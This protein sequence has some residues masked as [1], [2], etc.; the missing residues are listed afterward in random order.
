M[1]V[2]LGRERTQGSQVVKQATWCA[3]G[4]PSGRVRRA[5]AGGELP[6]LRAA[7]RPRSSLSRSM[8]AVVAAR[9]G[10]VT[11]AER[12]FHETAATDL[13][14][15]RGGSAGGVRIAALGGLWQTAMFGFVGLSLRPDGVALDPQLP[16]S[17]RVVTFRLQWRGRRLRFRLDGGSRMAGVTLERGEPMV[18]HVA[19]R[20]HGLELGRTID[21]GWS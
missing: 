18:V 12:Y 8:H 21:A 1:D 5:R 17:W 10:D 7:L 9:L 20:P 2:V 15:T 14:D 11:M 16:P 13:A 19:G 4:A 6:V 3:P